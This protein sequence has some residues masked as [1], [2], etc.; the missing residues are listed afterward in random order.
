VHPKVAKLF[1]SSFILAGMISPRRKLSVSKAL[2]GVD[3][4]L[5]Q[6]VS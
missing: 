4:L 1:D 3:E 5:P 2:K 6:A